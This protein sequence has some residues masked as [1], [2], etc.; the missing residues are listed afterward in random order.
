MP[1]L[2]QGDKVADVE[3]IEKTKEEEALD[4]DHETFRFTQAHRMDK[5]LSW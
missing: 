3:L 1:C 2:K 5:A 4:E